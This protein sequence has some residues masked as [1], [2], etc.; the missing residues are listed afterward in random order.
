MD[1]TTLTY[2]FLILVAVWIIYRF[3]F[4]SRDEGTNWQISREE[5]AA[6][7]KHS[8]NL[9][10]EQAIKGLDKYSE[11][12]FDL[13]FSRPEIDVTLFFFL[14][15][16]EELTSALKNCWV[17]SRDPESVASQMVELY[18]FI[19]ERT[20]KA[21]SYADELLVELEEHNSISGRPPLTEAFKQYVYDVMAHVYFTSI[22]DWEAIECAI[23]RHVI[24]INISFHIHSLYELDI[25]PS[26][27]DASS[28]VTWFYNRTLSHL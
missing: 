26:P 1:F 12:I 20:R 18:H 15:T 22:P 19:N 3:V 27:S 11:E 7:N 23:K 10:G 21:R 25:L 5:E 8:A 16:E 17:N 2:I 14:F 6:I 24:K 4:A 13:I 28:R 9:P